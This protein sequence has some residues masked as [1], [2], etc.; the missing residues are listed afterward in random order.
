[1]GIRRLTTYLEPY[2][3]AAT[4]GCSNS[5]CSV[6]EDGPTS[7]VIDGPGLAYHIFYR[8]LAW[9]PA[10]WHALDALPSYKEIGDATLLFLQ[11]LS[12]HGIVMYG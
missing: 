1:M 9:K 12:K 5:T 4:I 8:I 2:A 7:M 3:T 11:E 10:S 6:H